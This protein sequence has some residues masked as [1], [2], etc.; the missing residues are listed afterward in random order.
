[1]KDI[2]QSV[3]DGTYDRPLGRGLL[4]WRV[5]PLDEEVG[6]SK[7]VVELADGAFAY[8]RKVDNT[9]MLTDVDLLRDVPLTFV[10]LPEALGVDHVFL[11][12]SKEDDPM[13]AKFGMYHRSVRT[14]KDGGFEATC[15][16]GFE[17]DVVLDEE[18]TK[19]LFSIAEESESM[20]FA[21]SSVGRG[22][23]FICRYK[24]QH[25]NGLLIVDRFD[26]DPQHITLNTFHVIGS[27][28]I[29]PLLDGFN[30]LVSKAKK[31]YFDYP[32]EEGGIVGPIAEYMTTLGFKT[33]SKAYIISAAPKGE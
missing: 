12:T 7:H 4:N 14:A 20:R 22:A 9:A 18:E 10:G 31:G 6:E 1:M 29:L 28:D 16:V 32:I 2:T 27:Q 13:P 8:L 5:L 15:P 11:Y 3:L 33:Y 25:G 26:N 21:L 24:S 30:Y 19:R 23:S 17:E